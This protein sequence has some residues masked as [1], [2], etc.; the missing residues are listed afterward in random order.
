MIVNS[1]TNVSYASG[2]AD[3]NKHVVQPGCNI[4]PSGLCDLFKQETLMGIG[5][6]NIKG[7]LGAHNRLGNSSR[8]MTLKE[9]LQLQEIEG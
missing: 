6:R 4:M 3:H 8:L 5:G 9:E 2:E 7:S 1:E